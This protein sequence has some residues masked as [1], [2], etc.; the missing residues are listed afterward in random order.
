L[1]T[2]SNACAKLAADATDSIVRSFFAAVVQV[3]GSFRLLT[4]A[5]LALAFADSPSGDRDR[6][7][8]DES[9]GKRYLLHTLPCSHLT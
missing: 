9:W 3:A 6:I 5:Q 7:A 8:Q 2:F 4:L 1:N